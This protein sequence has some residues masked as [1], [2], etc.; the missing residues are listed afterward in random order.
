MPIY[1]T[2][3]NTDANGLPRI[4]QAGLP[5]ALYLFRTPSPR[6]EDA[7]KQAARA[8]SGKLL[9]AKVYVADSPDVHTQYGAPPLPA[10]I[11]LKAGEV[12]S[13]A[14]SVL[15]KDVPAHIDYLL[16]RGAKPAPAPT[17]AAAQPTSPD[18]PLP[19]TDATFQRDVLNSP[20][21]VLVDFWA[22]WCAPCRM[23]APS[24]ENLAREYA[25]RVKIVKLDVDAN[26]YTANTYRVQGIPTMMLF[27]NG[28]AI[29]TQVGALPQPQIEQ[30]IRQAL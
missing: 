7:L 27:K 24:L 30:F 19:T 20:V 22:A 2:P 4:L 14:D 8:E 18:K 16:G 15:P 13:V 12:Q 11:T 28:E 26:P 6:V 1:D 3:L 25:G 9:I 17:S 23:I 21:P 10:L 5:V 29:G